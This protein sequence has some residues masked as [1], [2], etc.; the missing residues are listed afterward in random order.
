[1][2]F[3]DIFRRVEHRVRE[4]RERMTEKSRE[5]GGRMKT[6]M[7]S[8]SDEWMETAFK[9]YREMLAPEPDALPA[10]FQLRES[11]FPRRIY[12]RLFPVSH[13]MRMSWRYDQP[14][15]EDYTPI[16]PESYTGRGSYKFVYRLPWRMV[17][18]VSKEILPSDVIIGSTFREVA[19]NPDRFLSQEELNLMEH[20]C[21][22]RNGSARRE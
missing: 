9:R 21:K 19:A 14:F 12:E 22:G 4:A 18:K 7:D 2:K 1:M 6:I 10:D 16:P 11:S 20:A 3:G 17:L 5:A 8:F 13:V 15:L